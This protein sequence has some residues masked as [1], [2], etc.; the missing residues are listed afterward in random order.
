M[1]G[2][3]LGTPNVRQDGLALFGRS[4]MFIHQP[5][6]QSTTNNDRTMIIREHNVGRTRTMADQEGTMPHVNAAGS[7]FDIPQDFKE[8]LSECSRKILQNSHQ[9]NIDFDNLDEH[10]GDVAGTEV[11]VDEGADSVDVVEFFGLKSAPKS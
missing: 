9:W 7:K 6:P 3:N 2:S 5:I 8:S 11:R 4:N 1:A 10:G